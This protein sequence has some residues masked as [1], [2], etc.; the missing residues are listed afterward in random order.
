[1]RQLAER[2]GE[3]TLHLWAAG[4]A[5]D[6]V[7]APLR[8]EFLTTPLRSAPVVLR[9]VQRGL[10]RFSDVRGYSHSGLPAPGDG[11]SVVHLSHRGNAHTGRWPVDCLQCG[12]DVAAE[13]RRLGVGLGGE[14]IR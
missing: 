10:R 1:M 13:L 6:D 9:E 12:K 8:T 2:L 7:P 3:G 11:L 5:H 4:V 14:W